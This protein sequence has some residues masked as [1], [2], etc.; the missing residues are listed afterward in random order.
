MFERDSG[1]RW[2]VFINRDPVYVWLRDDTASVPFA[3]LVGFLT[4]C[5]V[6]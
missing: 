6:L 5:L 1:V 4:V 2:Q 3:A